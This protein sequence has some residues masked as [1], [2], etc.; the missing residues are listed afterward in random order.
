MANIGKKGNV[1]VVRFRFR[2]REFKRS[3]KTTDQREAEAARHAAEWTIHRILTGQVEVPPNID[4]GDFIVSGGLLRQ[5][6]D[7]T[8]APPFPTTGELITR[9]LESKEN[10]ISESYLGSQRIHLRHLTKHLGE[11]VH[12]PCNAVRQR[13]VEEYLLARLKIRDPGTVARERVT[14]REFYKWVHS[15]KDVP[16]FDSP[17]VGLPTFKT[18]RDRDPFRTT[19]EVEALVE[20]G[21]LTDEQASELWDCLYLTPEEIA[22]LLATVR[23]RAED[24][25]SFLLHAIPAY[26]GMRRGEVLRLRW[27]D[28]DLDHGYITARSRKQSRKRQETS[29]R[30][31]LHPEL[32]QHLLEWQADRKRGQFVIC[33]GETLAP[34][35]PD[36]A[37]RYFWAPMRRTTWCLDSHRN[38]FKIGF[39]SYRHSFASNLAAAGVDQRIIDEFMGH[40]TEE[41]RKRYRHLFPKNRRSAIECFSLTK[42][43]TSE[44]RSLPTSGG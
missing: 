28:V 25:M 35:A 30:I 23:E 37:N 43:G 42:A 8:R 32:R 29:R 24:Q 33:H 17:I 40:Q 11:L 9:Y 10:T 5:L 2:D 34:L 14:I 31:E 3:L 44:A 39:H 36:K 41:M 27:V 15:R 12:R 7:V 4:V 22:D 13:N 38:W 1:F 21:G 18:S 19:G 6:P 16:T 20:R 26:T